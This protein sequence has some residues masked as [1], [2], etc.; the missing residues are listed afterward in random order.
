MAQ[1]SSQQRASRYGMIIAHIFAHHYAP[2]ARE[3]VFERGDLTHACHELDIA[4]PG[5]LGDI[6]YTFRYRRSLPDSILAT[7]PTD[8]EWLIRGAGDGRYRFVLA[9]ALNIAPNTAL[10]NIKVPDATPGIIA[11][12]ALSDEQA[13]LAKVRYN[14]LIDIFS[15]VTCYSLQNHLRTK[16]PDLGQ[17]ET[18]EIYVGIDQRGAQYIFPVQAKGGNDRLGRVQI[19]QDIALCSARFPSLICRPIA[20]QFITSDRGEIIALFELVEQDD[21]IKIAAERH[22]RLVPHADVSEADLRL[23]GVRDAE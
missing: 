11:K 7:A 4:V 5:N 16:V 8:E 15:R 17:V 10:A 13:L 12:Y 18:D 20:A 23:Y 3:F 9:K 21:E 1:R 22:Y 2:S 19:E 14:R 6:V